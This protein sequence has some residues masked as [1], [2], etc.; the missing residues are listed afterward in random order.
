M[1]TLSYVLNRLKARMGAK[2]RRLEITDEQLIN[3][4]K[5]E[6]LPTFSIYFPYLHTIKIN[7]STDRVNG[8]SNRFFLRSD[9]PFNNP[10]RLYPEVSNLVSSGQFGSHGNSCLSSSAMDAISLQSAMDVQSFFNVPVTFHFH[11]PAQITIDPVSVGGVINCDVN[12]VHPDVA[13]IHN[14]L[15]EEFMK[16]AEYD[17]KIDILGQR[18]FFSSVGTVFGEMELNLSA[19]ESAVDLRE[20]LLLKFDEKHF[21]NSSAQKIWYE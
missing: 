13:T 21:L 4:I 15:R 6:T 8:F 17:M 11:P 12:A 16:L 18:N 9:L 19:L 7:L 5:T 1:L 3:L 20:E 10:T 2:I 14:N